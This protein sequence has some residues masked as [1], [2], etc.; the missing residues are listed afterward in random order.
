MI[1]SRLYAVACGLASIKTPQALP[2]GFQQVSNFGQNPTNL[3]LHV[4][5]PAKL[6]PKPAVILALHGCGGS[7]PA[8]AS[9]SKYQ[10]LAEQ[11]GFVVLYPSSKRD[12]NCWDVATKQTLTHNGGGESNGLANIVNWAITNFGADPAQVF[13]SGTSSGCMMTNVMVST[14]P[15]LFKAASCYSGVAA[16]CLAGSPGSSPTSADQTCAQGRIQKTGEQWAQ[17]VKGMNPGYTGAYPPMMTFHGEADNFVS[18]ANLAEQLKQWSTIFGVS[19][20]KNTTN[21]PLPG[22]T[23]IVYGDGTKLVGYSA[24]GVG[25]VVPVHEASDMKWF[26]L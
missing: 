2:A 7:G 23:Q 13:V 4:Y 1:G 11:K 18:Y 25:H 10:P 14:Y 26:G 24:R 6:A 22:Y 3:D 5:V 15:E 21:T 8:Y 9:Q 16:G 20:T 17:A 12:S 19:F